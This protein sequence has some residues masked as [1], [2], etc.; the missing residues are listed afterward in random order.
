MLWGSL[1]TTALGALRLTMEE[2]ALRYGGSC[3]YIFTCMSAY[4]RGLDGMIGFIDT[5]FTQHGTTGNTT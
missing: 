4:R 1:V 2:K 3:E 5:L